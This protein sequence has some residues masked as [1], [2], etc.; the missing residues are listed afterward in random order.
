MRSFSKWYGVLIAGVM[1]AG[2]LA[3]SP[4]DAKKV[5]TDPAPTTA[6][7]RTNG[8]DKTTSAVVDGQ[9]GATLTCGKWTLEVPAGAYS[10]T[11]TITVAEV[12]AADGAPTVDLKIS[13]PSLNN[14]T[15]PVWLSHRDTSNENKSIYWWDPANQV[16]REVPGQLRTFFDAMGWELRAPLWHFSQYSVRGGRAGW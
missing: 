14:F 11:A 12:S 5:G 7:L 2:V 13:D 15:R 8:A 3:A 4:A 10:G 16:W 1:V 9:R 6:A